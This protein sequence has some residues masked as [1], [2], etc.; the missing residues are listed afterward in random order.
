MSVEV[1]RELGIRVDVDIKDS[2]SATWTVHPGVPR[3]FDVTVEPDLSNAAPFLA[4]ALVC[5]GSVA[6]PDWPTQTTQA[7]N[8]L[9]DLLP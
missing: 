3:S 8:A 9:L 2:T 1:L 7:G 5:G 4:A 6:I